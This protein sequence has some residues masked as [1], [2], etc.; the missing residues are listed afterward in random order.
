MRK[1]LGLLVL[2][3]VLFLSHCDQTDRGEPLNIKEGIAPINGTDIYYKIMGEGDPIIM[4]HGGPMLEHGYLVP[5]FK[6]LAKNYKLI[7]YDQRISG[8][9]SANVD[10]VETTLDHFVEDI[11]ELRN[12]FVV[13][14]VHLIAHSWGGLL[15]MKYAIKYPSNL[16]SLILLNSMPASSELWHRETQIMGERVSEEDSLKRQEIINSDLF[17]TDPQ[18]AIEQLLVLSFRNQFENLSMVDSLDFYI[19]ADYMIR[20]QRF[21]NLMGELSNYNLHPALE[22]LDTPTLLIY[23]ENEPAINI[24]GQKLHSIL[25]NSELS[26]IQNSG[27]FPFIEESDLFL[28]ELGVFLESLE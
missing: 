19:P 22:S 23:G 1:L 6:P 26:V 25:T 16:K 4:I 7:Y 2:I 3:V 10:S 17:Q 14:K 21:G 18:Q 12:A 13:G 27:H 5:Y 9:S 20:S 24:S 11:E 15:A 28:N 8:R